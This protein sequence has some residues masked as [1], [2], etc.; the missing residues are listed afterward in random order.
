MLN[1]RDFYYKR[2]NFVWYAFIFIYIFLFLFTF[3][4]I[5]FSH[6]I[7]IKIFLILIL[8]FFQAWFNQWKHEFLH[9]TVITNKYLNIFFWYLFSIPIFVNPHLNKD[10]HLWHHKNL[11][12]DK[13]PELSFK[14]RQWYTFKEIMIDKLKHP[15]LIDLFVINIKIFF[16]NFYPNYVKEKN[17]KYIKFDSFLLFFC[18]LSIIIIWIYSWNYIYVFIWYF[19]LEYIWF[20]IL[21]VFDISEHR[22]CDLKDFYNDSRTV[23]SNT[24]ITLITWFNNYHSVHHTDSI[25]KSVTFYKRKKFFEKFNIKETIQVEKSYIWFLKKLNNISK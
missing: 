10:F 16:L 2:N 19:S 17:I 20:N 14:V 18:H 6:H 3:V 24:F 5:F 9:S 21:T 1:N 23:L 11:W 7:L 13:D 22:L 15:F 8:W 4:S 12:T 25:D